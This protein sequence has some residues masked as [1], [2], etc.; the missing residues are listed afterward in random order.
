MFFFVDDLIATGSDSN[1]FTIF[2]H[3]LDQQFSIKDLGSLNY[4]LSVEITPTSHGLYYL[5]AS[6]F[7]TYFIALTWLMLSPF[8]VRLNPNLYLFFLVILCLMLIHI[9]VLLVP[10]NTLLSLGKKYP[11]QSIEYVHLCNHPPFL[12][13][14]LSNRILRFLKGSLH[15]GFP[16]DLCLIPVW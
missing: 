15:D 3:F 13:G 14:Q 9:L 7:A 11:T 10:F 4:F 12:I 5:K 1:F 6:T 16:Y 2:I 8:L